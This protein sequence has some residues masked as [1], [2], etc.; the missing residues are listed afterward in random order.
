MTEVENIS[1]HSKRPREPNY[2]SFPDASGINQ[3]AFDFS[4][5]SGASEPLLNGS[6]LPVRN[7]NSRWTRFLG[8]SIALS[9][10]VFMTIYSSL[11]K[12]LI[13][14]DSMQ[15]ALVRGVIQVIFMSL[16]LAI[17]RGSLSVLKNTRIRWLLAAIAITGGLR[18]IFIF[19]SFTKLPLGDSTAILFSS[20]VIVMG[21]SVCLLKERCG[22]FRVFAAATLISG[23]VLVA[24]PPFLFGS[25]EE[26]YDVLAYSFAIGAQV[27]SAF[28]IVL[29]KLIARRVKKSVSM[30]FIGLATTICAG[31]GL[32][33]LGKPSLLLH[34]PQLAVH[35]WLL[36]ISI[37]LLG[38]AQQYGL[39]WAVAF[40]SPSVVTSVRSLQ[41]LM[42]FGVQVVVFNQQPLLTDLVG[43]LLILCTIFAITL[44]KSR[45][46]GALTAE[47]EALDASIASQE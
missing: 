34:D 24:K 6:S 13:E 25:P 36:A 9:S 44:E 2:G 7:R 4:G 37:A 5:Q 31:V 23:V 18:V 20:P 10:G 29:L 30:L 1:T 8:I 21:L 16:I 33:A 15:V 45:N 11:L 46:E 35:D 47:E 43:A 32:A 41:I 14:M 39:I 26:S 42:A 17:Q 3:D 12:L 27:M 38:M 40:E 28:G 22:I 19:S